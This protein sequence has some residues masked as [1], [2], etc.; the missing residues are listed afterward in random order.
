MAHSSCCGGELAAE[1]Q[2]ISNGGR[3]CVLG[4]AAIVG[5]SSSVELILILLSETVAGREE[6]PTALLVHLP[7]VRLLEK[8]GVE[9]GC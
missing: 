9:I 5:H 2:Q 6:L 3:G 8:R 4:G 7:Y 1:G